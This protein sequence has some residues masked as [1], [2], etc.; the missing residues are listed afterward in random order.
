M[1]SALPNPATPLYNH[2]L[3]HIEQWLTN[4][5]C[6][7]DTETLHVWHVSYPAWVA[8]IFL[9]IEELTVIYKTLDNSTDETR[10]TFKYSLSRQDIESAVFSGP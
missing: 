4:N 1:N 7:R 3:P 9:D 10:R 8:D 6:E 5:G 2:T